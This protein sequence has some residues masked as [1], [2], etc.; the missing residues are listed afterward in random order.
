MEGWKVNPGE[1]Y[2]P[3]HG[4]DGKYLVSNMGNIV[5]MKHS[6]WWILKVSD[7][8]HGYLYFHTGKKTIYVHRAVAEAFLDRIPGKNV[9]NHKDY[10]THNNAAE[11]LEW[12]TQKE[13]VQHSRPNMCKPKSIVTSNTGYKY[14]TRTKANRFRVVKGSINKQFRTL[15][16][17]IA[18]RNEVIDA[19]SFTK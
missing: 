5:S 8:G 12:C 17:A 7:N 9:V 13:N 15:E 2:R 16:D 4:T 11:N 6:P 18:Y 14:I 19:V 1:E 3:V 10:N